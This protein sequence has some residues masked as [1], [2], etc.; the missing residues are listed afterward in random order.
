MKQCETYPSF[1]IQ[2][3]TIKNCMERNLMANILCSMIHRTLSLFFIPR[4]VIEE[5]RIDNSCESKNAS[6]HGEHS[7]VYA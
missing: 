3:F 2:V 6:I 5:N 4:L 7:G 1:I